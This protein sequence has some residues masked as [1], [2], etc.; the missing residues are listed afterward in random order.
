MTKTRAWHPIDGNFRVGRV[1]QQRDP[2]HE[3]GAKS[4][5]PQNFKQET[6]QHG[7]ESAGDI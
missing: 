3:Q 6:P 5:S 1:Q 7:V 4:H 2:F